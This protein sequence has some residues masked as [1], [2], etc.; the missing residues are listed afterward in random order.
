MRR[1]PFWATEMA[2][3]PKVGIMADWEGR[4][5]STAPAFDAAIDKVP[6]KVLVS[7]MTRIAEMFSTLVLGVPMKPSVSMAPS[8][9]LVA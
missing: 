7:G 3:T 9:P 4:E 5:I 8:H 2:P 1:A 6:A